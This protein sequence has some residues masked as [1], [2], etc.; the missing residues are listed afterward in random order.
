MKAQNQ[1]SE[2]EGSIFEFLSSVFGAHNIQ[3]VLV[4]GYALNANKV[5]RMTF[6]IDFLITADDCAKIEPDLIMAGY[7]IFNR[8]DAFV[9]FKN[10]RPGFRDLDF[11]IGDAHTKEQLIS[12]GKKVTIAGKTFNVPSPLHLIAMKLHSMGGNRKRELKDFPDIVQIM[13]AN[14]I[15]PR[16][17]DVVE[18]FKK[19][20]LMDLHERALKAIGA[21][22][23]K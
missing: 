9:Q 12:Q 23:E 15:N 5:Q 18:M 20:N 7:S 21:E 22:N 14:G 1:F 2:I 10:E 4:G 3:S 6:D 17:G 19:Y 11:L 8:Q 13:I 16:D